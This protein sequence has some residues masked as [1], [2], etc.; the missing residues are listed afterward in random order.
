MIV[1]WNCVNTGSFLPRPESCSRSLVTVIEEGCEK[2]ADYI[3]RV[4]ARVLLPYRKNTLDALGRDH[5]TTEEKK[6]E[7]EEG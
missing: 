1:K 4:H 5:G 7:E 3:M 2:V 6:E